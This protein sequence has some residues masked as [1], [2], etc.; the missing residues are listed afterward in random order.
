MD[1]TQL[2]KSSQTDF[3]ELGKK[4]DQLNENFRQDDERFWQLTV[5]KAGNGYAIIRFLPKAAGE[6]VPFVR[7][8]DHGFKGPGGWYI[9]LSRTSLKD[10]TGQGEPDPCSEYNTIQWNTGGQAGKDFV[11]GTPGNPGSKRRLH[12]ISNVLI[13]DDPAD[14]SKNGKVYLFKYGKKIFDKLQEAMKPKLPIHKPMNPFDMWVGANFVLEAAKEDGYRNYTRS[15]FEPP[16]PIS[17]DDA[18]MEKLWKSEYSLQPFLDPAL[19]KSYDVLSRKLHRVLNVPGIA[20]TTTVEQ[21]APVR[22]PRQ[23]KEKVPDEDSPPW[24]TDEDEDEDHL[25]KFREMAKI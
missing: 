22:Q 7:Y 2:K 5:D 3:A 1:F 9:E 17:D 25:Q 12:Y 18:V 4:L 13:I 14:P 8:Y 19:F 6:E 20:T 10:E 16:A 11:S 23:P 24:A 21:E 15:H